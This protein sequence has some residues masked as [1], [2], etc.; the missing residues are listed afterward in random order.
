MNMNRKKRKI[1][2]YLFISPFFILYAIFG[3]Y[4]AL[5]GIVTSFKT[6]TGSFTAENYQVVLTDD[7]FWK[8]ISNASIYMLGSIFIILPVALL[9]ALMLNSKFMGK[10][11]G[12]VSTV[13]FVP[14]VT[15]VIVVG[16]VFKLILRT[17]NGM[18]N[19]VLQT[20][21]ITDRPI[22]FLSDP[23]W[24]IPSILLI[25]CWR[26]FGIN[27]LYFLSGLQGIPVELGEAARID[28][29]GRWKEFWYITLPLL[30][31]IMTY[32]VFVAITGSFAMFGEVLTL[33]PNGSAVGSRDSMLFP[34]IY[35]YNTMFKNN[36][37]NRAA[38][39]GYVIAVILLIIT[40]I[41]R[42][43]FREKE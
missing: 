31:P 20:I 34:I 11:S 2:P 25:G 10:K 41:Q 28:G 38:A 35:L 21:G 15:S 3:L 39:M 1:I 4:P 30:K 22:K 32:I 33:V 9:A 24:A 40:T 17:N 13:F 29:A 19:T 7:R 23:V 5:A 8:A 43:L 27:S 36:R 14:N 6:K 37:I 42:Y 12:F 18:I 16:I 26:Y